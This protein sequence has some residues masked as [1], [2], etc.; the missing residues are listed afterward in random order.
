[1]IALL[2]IGGFVAELIG[3]GLIYAGFR[4]VLRKSLPDE[5]L[6]AMVLRQSRNSADVALARAKAFVTRKPY[7]EATHT[8]V[9]AGSAHLHFTGS[10]TGYAG[11]PPVT[12]DPAAFVKALDQKLIQL[13]VQLANQDSKVD[14]TKTALEAQIKQVSDDVDRRFVQRE[15]LERE[16]TRSDLT[17]QVWG[18]LLV[19]LGLT[20]SG[21]AASVQVI[22]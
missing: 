5:R 9:A 13:G 14:R 3:L 7:A 11:L 22:T 8:I 12:D 18:W 15:E 21:L 19:V 6:A 1:M 10:A 17:L 16:F 20:M 4:R 2:T